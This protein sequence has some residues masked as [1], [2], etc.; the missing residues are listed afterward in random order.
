MLQI[1]SRI[2]FCCA[3]FSKPRHP[4]MTDPQTHPPNAIKCFTG[5]TP[6]R[7]HA[8]LRCPLCVLSVAISVH[9]CRPSGAAVTRAKGLG[10]A[11]GR[12]TSTE[13]SLATLW[14][15]YAAAASAGHALPNDSYPCYKHTTACRTKTATPEERKVIT[16][17][18]R[19]YRSRANILT[20]TMPAIETRKYV[21]RGYRRKIKIPAVH[22][23]GT[24]AARTYISTKFPAALYEIEP[25]TLYLRSLV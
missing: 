21:T 19:S 15:L 1:K 22:N 25:N 24:R 6:T 4:H 10:P 14:S 9:C 5:H 23:S 12:P 16:A 8:R 3:S 18:A 7:L 2:G 11:A 17:P 20:A 13:E